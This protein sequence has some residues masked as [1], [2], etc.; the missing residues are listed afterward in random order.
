[1]NGCTALSSHVDTGIVTQI[2][3]SHPPSPTGIETVIVPS[4]SRW[5]SKFQSWLWQQG[6][7]VLVTLP[8]REVCPARRQAF[9]GCWGEQAGL[10]LLR[11]LPR[12]CPKPAWIPQVPH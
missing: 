8:S 12:E 2:E 4:S 5:K 11:E 7:A 6:P 10:P 1:M 3:Y 9:E